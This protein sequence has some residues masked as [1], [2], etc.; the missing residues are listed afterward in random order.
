L[1]KLL[2]VITFFT[3]GKVPLLQA[4]DGQVSSH[5]YKIHEFLGVPI[6][7]SMLTTW[8]FAI[9]IIVV[10]KIFVGRAQLIPNKGQAVFECVFE[11][12]HSVIEPIVGRKMVSKTLPL[13]LCLF[14]FI[15]IHNWTGLLPGVGAFGIHD[16]SGHLV[17]WFRPA[18]SDLNTTVA[19]A[20]V[21]IIGWLYFV[22]RYAGV[23]LFLYDIFGNKADRKETPM[24]LY[25][26]L[27]LIFLLVGFIEMISIC[28]RPITLS[29][30]L[31]GNVFGG[32]T[33]LSKIIN[34]SPWYVPAALPFYL[35][36]TLVGLIQ[37]LVFV[38]L[39]A[40]YIGLIC[41]HEE[42]H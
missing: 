35:L 16:E 29:M 31:F 19:L 23:K 33:L 9:L 6:T 7:N 34:M 17:Y 24:P 39:T 32:E 2:S 27:S 18:N 30:R 36:E 20:S 5:A 14:I 28:I 11:S 3:I 13:L 10:A 42:E 22:F 21:A 41:N 40:V 15:L 1:K 12:V 4:A 8:V 38:L 37:A 26:F 25:I